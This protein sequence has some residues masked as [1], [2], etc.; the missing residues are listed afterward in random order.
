VG[1]VASARVTV[2]NGWVFGEDCAFFFAVWAFDQDELV[3]G[4]G[5][6]VSLLKEVNTLNP[7]AITAVPAEK[8]S[9]MRNT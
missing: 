8:M 4:L 9:G 5:H 3:G 1:K 7:P 2:K 6:S